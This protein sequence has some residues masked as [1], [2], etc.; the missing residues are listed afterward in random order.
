MFLFQTFLFYNLKECREDGTATIK[1]GGGIKQKAYVFGNAVK[2]K[3]I[4][5]LELCKVW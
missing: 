4:P 2:K 1:A 3:K 5:P